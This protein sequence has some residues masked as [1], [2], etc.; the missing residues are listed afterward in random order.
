MVVQQGIANNDFPI[1]ASSRDYMVERGGI[2]GG[3]VGRREGER[4]GSGDPA[5]V[6]VK[7]HLP[8]FLHHGLSSKID[9]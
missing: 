8:D 9:F 6:L 2:E 4:G 3:G 1:S 5:G 7:N